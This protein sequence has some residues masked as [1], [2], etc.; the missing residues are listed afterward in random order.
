MIM[1]YEDVSALKV[2]NWYAWFYTD[3]VSHQPHPCFTFVEGYLD[4]SSIDLFTLSFRRGSRRNY[5]MHI[6]ILLP[7][8]HA[9]L[10]E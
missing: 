1:L 9:H 3:T 4:V 2:Q 7:T 6:Q 10:H 5:I 8:M